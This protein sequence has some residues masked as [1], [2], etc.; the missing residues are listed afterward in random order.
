MRRTRTEVDE[1][2][3]VIDSGIAEPADVTVVERK[4]G[5]HPDT[6]ADH[7]AERLSQV[8]SRHTLEEFG[9]FST[10]TSTSSPC[11]AVPARSA[12]GPGASPRR[13]GYW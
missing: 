4:G 9:L 13:C 6:L 8:Y 5:G 3:I 1:S 12:T 2:V 10:I 11:S 7:L